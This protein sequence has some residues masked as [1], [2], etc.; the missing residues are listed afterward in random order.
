M[1]R[2][3]VSIPAI[4]FYLGIAVA[5]P[6]IAQS[7]ANPGVQSDASQHHQM[8]SGMMKDMSQQMTG[9]SDQMSQGNLTPEQGKQMAQR[10]ERMSGM[11]HRM[12]GL[13]GK[14]AM[15]DPEFQKQMGQMRKQMNDMMRAAPMS[16]GAK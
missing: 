5:V 14:P 7:P 4:I 11:M 1:I 9:M 13:A 16:P 10:M 6:A 8:M 2:K 3:P 15:S 12:S